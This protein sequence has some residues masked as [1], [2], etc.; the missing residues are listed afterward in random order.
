MG[1][2]RILL[3]LLRQPFCFLLITKIA[4]GCQSGIR[5]ILVQ[6]MLEHQNQQ[7]KTLFSLKFM[8]KAKNAIWHLDY[9][10]MVFK[11][12]L[13]LQYANLDIQKANRMLLLYF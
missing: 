8:L 1:Y 3:A 10:G 4:Q 9:T 12:L 5:L 11:P 6:D 13:I 7:K 2:L